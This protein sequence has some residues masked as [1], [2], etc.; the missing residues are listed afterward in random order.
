MEVELK[1]LIDTADVAAFRHHP[2]LAHYALATHAH[3]A[4]DQHLL[5]YT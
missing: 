1:L 5:R 3:A 2:F 4:T